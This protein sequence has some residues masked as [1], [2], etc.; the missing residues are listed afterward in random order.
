M[1]SIKEAGYID[2]ASSRRI[3]RE[4]QVS[5]ISARQTNES[6]SVATDKEQVGDTLNLSASGEL[7]LLK[8]TEVEQYLREIEKIKTTDERTLAQ[9]RE[10][11]KAG[12]YSKPDVVAQIAGKIVSAPVAPAQETTAEVT[13]AQEVASPE[14]EAIRA[15]I[16]AG[17]YDTEDV[18]A[19]IADKMINPDYLIS[20]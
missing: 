3:E 5:E 17:Y 18:Y 16:R 20:E 2:Y 11:V 15:K 12:V 13:N 4:R 8:K 10:K 14:I 19:N 9:I 1:T 7:L 6:S